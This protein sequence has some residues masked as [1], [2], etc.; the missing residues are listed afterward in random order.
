MSINCQQLPT[1]NRYDKI[2]QEQRI[3]WFLSKCIKNRM[4]R[5][6]EFSCDCEILWFLGVHKIKYCVTVCIPSP[7]FI[8]VCSEQVLLGL[9]DPVTS[10]AYWKVCTWWQVLV[11]EY[12][13]VWS[14]LA[15]KKPPLFFQCFYNFVKFTCYKSTTFSSYPPTILDEP[16]LMAFISVLISTCMRLPGF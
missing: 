2:I 10:F 8:W 3:V 4:C 5:F 9:Y 14:C 11:P 6:V 13:R 1:V 7:R 15:V 12:C 16:L